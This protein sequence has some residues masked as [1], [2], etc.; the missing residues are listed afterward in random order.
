MKYIFPILLISIFQSTHACKKNHSQK[1]EN[2]P[3]GAAISA[4][5]APAAQ[6]E[7]FKDLATQIKDN[8]KNY[9]EAGGSNPAAITAAEGLVNTPT[10]SLVEI[11]QN[12]DTVDGLTILALNEKNDA[13][14]SNTMTSTEIGSN[15]QTNTETAAESSSATSTITAETISTTILSPTTPS[16][17]IVISINAAEQTSNSVV[18][19]TNIKAISNIAPPIQ[20]SNDDSQTLAITGGSIVAIFG[21]AAIVSYV[22]YHQLS[23]E[24]E[25]IKDLLKKDR[26]I[27]GDLIKFRNNIE[28]WTTEKK[29]ISVDRVADLNSRAEYQTFKT[30]YALALSK[31][32]EISEVEAILKA[33]HYAISENL[34]GRLAPKGKNLPQEFHLDITHEEIYDQELKNLKLNR[35]K[36]IPI[37]NR[38]DLISHFQHEKIDEVSFKYSRNSKI[39]GGTSAAGLSIGAILIGVSTISSTNLAEGTSET[40]PEALWMKKNAAL[41]VNLQ[42]LLARKQAPKSP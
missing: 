11:I 6:A 41:E 20:K 32:Y 30:K 8:A 4:L 24:D 27:V 18:E 21:I 31:I 36:P 17:P 37:R 35:K 16:T 19:D 7:N 33:R 39:A 40:S 34:S 9:L 3:Q 14:Q 12:N 13:T 22:A 42:I 28:T 23:R 38:S 5:E 10:N 25:L 26:E 1:V 29:T 2:K 15:T